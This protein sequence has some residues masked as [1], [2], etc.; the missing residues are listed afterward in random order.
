MT[1]MHFDVFPADS[2]GWL[3]RAL[4]TR[5]NV[6]DSLVHISGKH[7]RRRTPAAPPYAWSNVRACAPSPHFS[8]HSVALHVCGTM[9]SPPIKYFFGCEGNLFN[10]FRFPKDPSTRQKWVDL[11]IPG[12]Q[13]NNLRVCQQHFLP[14]SFTNLGQCTVGLATQLVLTDGSVPTILS[15][16]EESEAQVVSNILSTVRLVFIM[17]HSDKSVRG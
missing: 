6:C 13:L 12:Q 8:L 16:V 7:L 14:D 3:C 1:Y 11:L 2:L 17:R 10:L 15:R 4:N 5:D 9:P